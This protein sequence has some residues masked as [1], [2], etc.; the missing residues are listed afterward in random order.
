MLTLFWRLLIHGWSPLALLSLTIYTR[1]AMADIKEYTSDD[2]AGHNTRDDLWVVVNGN[3]KLAFGATPV[4][5]A[6][7]VLTV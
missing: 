2:V 3:G 1:F 4:I 7:A 5:W 6:I